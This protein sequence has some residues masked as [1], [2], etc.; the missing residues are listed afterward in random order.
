VFAGAAVTTRWWIGLVA[1]AVTL[2][3]PRL[4]G[5]LYALAPV[6]FVASRWFDQPELAWLALA[7]MV[8]AVAVRPGDSEP[9]FDPVAPNA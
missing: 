1:G 6:A 9:P 3:A 8:V 2:V 5:V 4:G 7:L